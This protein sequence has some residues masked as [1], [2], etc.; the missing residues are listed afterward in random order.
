MNPDTFLK[1]A[2]EPA[3]SL[4]PE[5][6][7]SPSAKRFLLAICLQES[8]LKYRRQIAGPARGWPMFEIN[9]VKGVLAHKS[10]KALAAQVIEKLEY[11]GV[12]TD[13]VMLHSILE[14]NDTLSLAFARLL[15]FTLPQSLPET[16]EQGWK[17]YIDGWRPGR[18]RREHWGACW[19]IAT[20]TV[21]C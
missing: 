2:I 5:D 1:I 12:A 17:Q 14:H 4:L 16:E 20:E 13:I 19:R 6:M 9:G 8:S 7:A 3:L 11:K 10:S 18:P 15:I 21:G